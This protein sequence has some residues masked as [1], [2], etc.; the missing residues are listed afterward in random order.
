MSNKKIYEQLHNIIIMLLCKKEPGV[1]IIDDAQWIDANSW[2][3]L[4][5]IFS[6]ST[7]TAKRFKHMIIVATRPHNEKNSIKT[8]IDWFDKQN[9]LTMRDFEQRALDKEQAA[10]TG[11]TLERKQRAS[12][13]KGNLVSLTMEELSISSMQ[14]IIAYELGCDVHDIDSE[15][16]ESVLEASGGNPA[17]AKIYVTWAKEKHI[18][19]E[20]GDFDAIET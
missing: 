20:P 8:F 12:G 19:I 5:K 13:I 3:L 9:P 11:A 4:M 7:A 2:E 10:Y 16:F 1:L 15:V 14:Q 18:I 6:G 17:N